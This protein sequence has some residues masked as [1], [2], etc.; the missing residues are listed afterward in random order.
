MTTKPN[1]GSLVEAQAGLLSN[2]RSLLDNEMQ[3]CTFTWPDLLEALRCFLEN[4]PEIS[5]LKLT[6]ETLAIYM[7]QRN[8]LQ[9]NPGS[10][11]RFSVYVSSLYQLSLEDRNYRDGSPWD[12]T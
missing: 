9:T 10:P 11:P 3:G 1:M 12:P 2:L 7:Q 5:P 8:W 4:H 6:P